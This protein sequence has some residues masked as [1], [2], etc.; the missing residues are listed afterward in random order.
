MTLRLVWESPDRV[1][2]TTRPSWLGR[3]FDWLTGREHY[4]RF[5]ERVGWLREWVWAGSQRNV[6]EHEAEA[7]DRAWERLDPQE[8]ELVSAGQCRLS[9]TTN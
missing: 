9:V 1:I 6:P 3:V 7:I 8:R 5:A 4:P 2:V